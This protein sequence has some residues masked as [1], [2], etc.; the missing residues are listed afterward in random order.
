MKFGD[1]VV[2]LIPGAHVTKI[3]PVV[4][5][6]TGAYHRERPDVIVGIL[7]TQHF[8]RCTTDYDLF[9]WKAA[10]LAAASCFSAVPDYNAPA[11]RAG[12][13]STIRS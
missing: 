7:T 6:S 10:G 12:D 9:D 2:G 11:K 8:D 4:V 1:V 3:R 5:L 13:W